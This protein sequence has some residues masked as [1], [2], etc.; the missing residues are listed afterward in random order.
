MR[1]AFL[2]DA[3]EESTIARSLLARPGVMR[4]IIYQNSYARAPIEFEG[5][6][7]KDGQQ[8]QKSVL[9]RENSPS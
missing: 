5:A 3:V 8:S 4:S 6:G 2:P 9:I 1:N 7:P